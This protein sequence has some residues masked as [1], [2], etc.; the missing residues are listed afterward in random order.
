MR[1]T[2]LKIEPYVLASHYRLLCSASQFYTSKLVT[3]L[4]RLSM[5]PLLHRLPPLDH[6]Y[7]PP[8]IVWA[9]EDHFS[10]SVNSAK[11]PSSSHGL[12]GS[13]AGMS[14]HLD[15]GLE[16]NELVMKVSMAAARS[17]KIDSVMGDRDTPTSLRVW[18]ECEHTW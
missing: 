9:L 2:V 17:A 7:C 13:L 16:Q 11:A 10:Y 6:V 8:G 4:K 15:H 14:I 3:G 12:Q 5:E 18:V 1:E